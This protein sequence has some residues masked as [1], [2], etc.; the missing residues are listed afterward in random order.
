[1]AV[2]VFVA[3]AVIV[4]VSV[5]DIAGASGVWRKAKKTMIAPMP[6][7]NANKPIAAG[8]LKDIEGILLPWTTLAAWAVFSIFARSAPHTRQ[9]VAS[10]FTRDPH[11]GHNLVGDVLFSGVIFYGVHGIAKTWRIIPA[12]YG[13]RCSHQLN[14]VS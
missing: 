13:H 14:E 4:A 9:R 11:V 5:V 10:S 2:S 6:R 12:F 3:V 1:M 7:N 8:R